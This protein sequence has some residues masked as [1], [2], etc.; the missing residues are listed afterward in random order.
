MHMSPETLILIVAAIV[1]V[2]VLAF[3]LYRFLVRRR[4]QRDF[5]AYYGD[6]YRRLIAETGSSG[7]A[8]ERLLARERRVAG[9][10]VH[11]LDQAA[12]DRY[13]TEWTRAQ[14]AFVSDPKAAVA[15]AGDV[16]E[17][18]LTEQG[19]PKADFDRL[20]ADLSVGYPTILQD[21]R[22]AHD[23]V[24]KD[25]EGKTNTE[26]LRQAMIRYKALFTALMGEPQQPVQV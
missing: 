26:D 14:A 10:H 9:Y 19:Y 20:S 8:E 6:E 21:F 17:K 3:V 5:A 2:L 7:K 15:Q 25:R 23:I 22:A 11:P 12:K 4:P 13:A 24:L 18:V 1:I 16:L